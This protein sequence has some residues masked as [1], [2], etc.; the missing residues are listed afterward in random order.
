M[1]LARTL[2][3]TGDYAEAISIL[4]KPVSLPYPVWEG[5]RQLLLAEALIG[6]ARYTD[7]IIQLR[8]AQRLIPQQNGMRLELCF[9]LGE[10]H[11]GLGE[12]AA[13]A[14]QFKELQRLGASRC[15]KLYLRLASGEVAP[16]HVASSVVDE[17]R[18]FW[19][20]SPLEAIPKLEFAAGYL[21]G[22]GSPSSAE[23]IE[24]DVR[25]LKS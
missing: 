15:A 13:A 6:K 18:S 24:G 10:A 25:Q 14:V 21:R 5:S 8:S 22:C 17:V 7:A 4:S 3:I 23:L 1:E 12:R 16:N 9:E 19:S 2:V 20:D 11:L